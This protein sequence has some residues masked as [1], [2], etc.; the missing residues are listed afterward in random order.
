LNTALLEEKLKKEKETH[1]RVFR[2]IKE[3]KTRKTSKVQILRVLCFLR[4]NF[5]IQILDLHSQQKYCCLSV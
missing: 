4:K 1:D 2:F 3:I 5:K